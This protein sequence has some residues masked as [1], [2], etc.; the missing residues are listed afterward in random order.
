M[1]NSLVLQ[2][3][4]GIY[5]GVCTCWHVVLLDPAMYMFVYL[6]RQT[7]LLGCLSAGSWLVICSPE[8]WFDSN[9]TTTVLFVA[10][11]M[12]KLSHNN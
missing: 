10:V 11:Q 6:S 8:I 5:V 1:T 2:Q 4:I 9:V 7:V 3:D 12:E